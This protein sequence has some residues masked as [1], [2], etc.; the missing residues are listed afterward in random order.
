MI[1]YYCPVVR[2]CP[3]CCSQFPTPPPLHLIY[4]CDCNFIYFV[5]FTFIL[6][7]FAPIWF[8][9]F[10][11]FQLF[12][13]LL[14]IQLVVIC[15]SVGWLIPFYLFYIYGF[16][17][18]FP[19]T[20][21]F[22]AHLHTFTF[23]H[24]PFTFT[25]AFALPAPG[26]TPH[27]LRCS[28]A[29]WFT[30]VVVR[31]V[32]FPLLFYLYPLILLPFP[33][34]PRLLYPFGSHLHLICYVPSWFCCWFRPF[35]LCLHDFDSLQLIYRIC[36]FTG[37]LLLHFTLFDLLFDLFTFWLLLLIYLFITLIYVVDLIW[38][39][40]LRL[41]FDLP[42][43]FC[44]LIC[45]CWWFGCWFCIL[46]WL[47]TDCEFPL[48]F[49]FILFALLFPFCCC[50]CTF[51]LL[52]D[53]FDSSLLHLDLLIPTPTFVPRLLF[54]YTVIVDLFIGW[55][56]LLFIDSR[57]CW[58][59]LCISP[60]YSRCVPL[61][62][63][64]IYVVVLLIICSPPTL[65][66]ITIISFCICL[67][68]LFVAVDLFWFIYLLIVVYL[69]ICCSLQ[70]DLLLLFYILFD[71]LYLF[72][73]TFIWLLRFVIC[74]VFVLLL[75]FVVVPWFIWRYLFILFFLFIPPVI[76]LFIYLLIV[77]IWFI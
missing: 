11:L 2:S 1:D 23:I 37:C 58:C 50:C 74:S 18:L 33:F 69:C 73:C 57:C 71:L 35:L 14:F 43:L 27:L 34:A 65:L 30:P 7:L 28:V 68:I 10:Q 13:L 64:L 40:Y 38:L 70:F 20:F 62:H 39:L 21:P 61:L 26:S 46:I 59:W 16:I 52:V 36:W 51:T 66:L 5:H 12:Q 6:L 48:L 19:V 4:I 67:V 77:F 15:S 25:F 60:I 49:Y 32:P 54:I 41:P 8:G 9:W 76:C 29:S 53:W 42:A 56:T 17:W 75:L 47:F 55:F 44:Q 24:L 31:V 72:I 63:L 3:G 45:C 22:V